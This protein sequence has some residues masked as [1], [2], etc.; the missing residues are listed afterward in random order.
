MI[1]LYYLSLLLERKISESWG[2]D[3][4]PDSHELCISEKNGLI[5]D[6][7]LLSKWLSGKSVNELIF[8]EIA[9][10]FMPFFYLA[11][12]PAAYY[13]GGYM[14]ASLKLIQIDLSELRDSFAFDHVI[15]YIG[16][17]SF[18]SVFEGYDNEKKMLILAFVEVALEV[19]NK[20][21]ETELLVSKTIS[22]Y[23]SEHT[24]IVF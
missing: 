12:A 10:N 3:A 16:S 5:D 14:I 24:K 19:I 2:R 23:K 6:S 4:I 9:E 17:Y 18:L 1:K 21:V 8:D 20:S 7:E 15:D 13:I 11:E 22:F